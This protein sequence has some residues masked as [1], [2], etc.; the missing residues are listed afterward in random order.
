MYYVTKVVI[1]RI[2]RRFIVDAPKSF[3]AAATLTAWLK[4]DNPGA[5]VWPVIS[6]EDMQLV[7]TANGGVCEISE[8]KR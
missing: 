2:T 3:V 1:K 6:H 8:P 5:G 4:A 7:T